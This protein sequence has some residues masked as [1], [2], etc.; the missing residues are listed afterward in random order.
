M[1]VQLGYTD[2]LDGFDECYRLGCPRLFEMAASWSSKPRRERPLGNRS[3]YSVDP[4]G[5]WIQAFARDAE[6]IEVLVHPAGQL[7]ARFE[8]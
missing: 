8:L 2:V 3:I 5:R 6:L 1:V 4:S 7:V